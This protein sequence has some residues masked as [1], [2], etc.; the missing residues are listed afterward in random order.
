[1]NTGISELIQM[2]MAPADASPSAKTIKSGRNADANPPLRLMLLEKA[3]AD[4][5]SDIEIYPP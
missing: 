4:S 3:D 2:R 5:S 1:V